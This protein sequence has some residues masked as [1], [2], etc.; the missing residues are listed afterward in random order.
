MIFVHHTSRGICGGLALLL[1][2]AAGAARPAAAQDR[3]ELVVRRLN[4]KGNKSLSPTL[5]AN[6][7]ATTN[8]GWFAR[9]APF[10]WLGLG[11]KR[12]FSEIDFQRDV[13]RIEVLYKQ[14]GFPDVQVDTLVRRTT[15]DIYLT[16]Q[17][18]EGEPV[19]VDTLTIRGLDS[20]DAQA[21]EEVV[22]DLP[23]QTGDIFNRILMQVSADTIARRLR[24]RGYPTADVLVGYE[25]RT[26]ERLAS[27]TLDAQPGRRAT[28]GSVRVE[29]EER[30]DSQTVVSLMPARPGRLYSQSDLF[31][32]QRN[33]YNSD[34]FRL[35]AVNI[36]TARFEPGSDSVPLVVHV[37][38][39]EPRGARAGVGYATND[40]FRGNAGIT[41]RNFLGQG[42]IVDLSGRVSKV[43]IGKPADWGFGRSIC[44]PLSADSIGSGLLNYNVTTAIRRPAFYSANNTLVSTVFAERRSEFKVFRRQEVGISV[45]LNRETPH[46][47]LPLALTYTVALGRTEASEFSFCAFFNACRPADAE[48]LGQRRRLATLTATGAIPRANNPIDPTRGYIAS[49]EVTFA[50][51]FIGSS[52]VLQFTRVVSEYAFYRPLARDIVFSARVRGGAIFAPRVALE[53][54]TSAYI[55][56]EQR[57]YGGGPS[58]VRGFQRN[59]L[60]PVVYV[61]TRSHADSMAAIGE[62]LDRDSVRVA[63][64]GGNTTAVG[65]LEVRVPAPFFRERL[66]LAAFVDMGAVWERGSTPA[67]LRV[68]PGVGLRVATPLGP[69][70]LDLAYNP[71]GLSPGTLYIKEPDNT[72]TP[73]TSRSPFS[74]DRPRRYT[75]HF[76]VGQPF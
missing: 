66:R 52:S 59:E 48:F 35:A 12:Y 4:F 58:D 23:L 70:R 50:S 33:L 76:A 61:T 40:C 44:S 34:L 21:A 22:V 46:R 45:G 49:G 71:Y 5:L 68:T 69:A 38:E 43:G 36:D 63:A 28:I 16:F 31:E 32:S 11:E 30:V 53:A 6:S 72:L 42:R 67:R 26:E 8:S 62:P 17:I 2:C 27:V 1:L 13:L 24:D 51:R 39:S 25:S 60:G 65:N 20:V 64:T 74:L 18:V 37:T 75:L 14:S 19:R 41:L 54:D 57:F 3:D 47:R 73:D 10:K 9:T 15:D 55:P 29:G 56:P 7:I